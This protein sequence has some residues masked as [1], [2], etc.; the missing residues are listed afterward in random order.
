MHAYMGL[1]EAPEELVGT[2]ADTGLHW[3]RFEKV[4]GAFKVVAG[5]GT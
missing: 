5:G 4:Q 3:V 1:D 2:D